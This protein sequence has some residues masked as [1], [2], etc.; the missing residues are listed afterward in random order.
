V[1]SIDCST[2]VGFPEVAERYFQPPSAKIGDDHA[3]VALGGELARDV[4]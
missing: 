1:R 4:R 2:S 3:F